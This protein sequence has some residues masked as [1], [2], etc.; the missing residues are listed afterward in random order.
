MYRLA[1]IGLFTVLTLLLAVFGS[2]GTGEAATPLTT[3]SGSSAKAHNDEGIEH[4]NQ[5][6]WDIAYE[7]FQE[8]VKADRAS[9]EAHYNLALAL[10]KMGRHGEAANH[11][12][13]AADLGKENPDIQRSKILQAHLKMLGDDVS[14]AP[15][16]PPRLMEVQ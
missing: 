15:P 4:Y 12:K 13:M 16:G 11:F 10:D 5:G 6:H 7:H 14:T 8:A 9:A 1:Q 3:A 2:V